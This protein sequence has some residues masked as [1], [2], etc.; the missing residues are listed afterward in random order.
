MTCGLKDRTADEICQRIKSAYEACGFP[1][2]IGDYSRMREVASALAKSGFDPEE[3]DP[4]ELDCVSPDAFFEGLEQVRRRYAQ[5]E[6]DVS[7]L[8]SLLDSALDDWRRGADRSRET[9]QAIEEYIKQLA[10]LG[11]RRLAYQYYETARELRVP[12]RLRLRKPPERRAARRRAAREARAL[13]EVAEEAAER[14]RPEVAEEL[15]REV[16][17][18]AQELARTDAVAVEL[19]RK[20]VWRWFSEIDL[21]DIKGLTVEQTTDGLSIRLTLRITEGEE[22]R[23]EER[24]LA[25]RLA[26]FFASLR[27]G[28]EGVGHAQ[29]GVYTLYTPHRQERVVG[30]A[31]RDDEGALQGGAGRGQAGEARGKPR[32]GPG[33]RSEGRGQLAGGEGRTHIARHVAVAGDA[34]EAPYAVPPGGASPADQAA[35]REGA[36]DEAEGPARRDA[37]RRPG[38]VLQEVARG[39]GEGARV[40]TS[41]RDDED[42]DPRGEGAGREGDVLGGPGRAGVFP[43]KPLQR[44]VPGVARGHTLSGG[45]D[46]QA[47]VGGDAGGPAERSV[48]AGMRGDKET[49]GLLHVEL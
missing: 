45:Q 35:D 34:E 42:G 28:E 7:S 10:E 9:A 32:G 31:G 44:R 29:A 17:I 18:A 2:D 11:E 15:A 16:E 12:I 26:A 37:P 47:G 38:G 23:E 39:G 19:A 49:H 14:G 8:V 40:A 24:K 36:A 6:A 5:P 22:G 30:Q 13:L 4:E 41:S 20:V 25:E 27:R 33:R 21:S 43:H 3:L 48:G 1:H 46:N